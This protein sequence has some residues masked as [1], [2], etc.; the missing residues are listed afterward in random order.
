MISRVTPR[1]A[2]SELSSLARNRFPLKLFAIIETDILNYIIVNFSYVDHDAGSLFRTSMSGNVMG[3]NF[4][5]FLIQA[6][7]RFSP[8]SRPTGCVCPNTRFTRE[9]SE[10]A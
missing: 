5:E 1:W 6:A 10:N 3:A 8:S 4:G 2:R 9:W 7:M